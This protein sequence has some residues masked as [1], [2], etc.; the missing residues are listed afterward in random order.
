MSGVLGI[1]FTTNHIVAN[2]IIYAQV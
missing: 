2:Y 1:F